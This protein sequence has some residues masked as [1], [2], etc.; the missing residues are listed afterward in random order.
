MQQLSQEVYSNQDGP[1][2]RV[3]EYVLKHAST[4]WLKP[5]HKSS[6]E[7][8]EDYLDF[9]KRHPKI[10]LD[11]GCGV[12]ESTLKLAAAYPDALVVGVDKSWLRLSKAVTQP[13]NTLFLRVDLFDFWRILLDN[14]VQIFK[15]KI[16]YPNP[17]PKSEHLMRRFHAHP[18]FP[19]LI[20]LCADIELRS[21]W[22]I[23]LLEFEIGALTL[24]LESSG[25]HS[26]EIQNESEA[27]TPFE[28]KYFLSQHE[29][30]QLEL[31][32]DVTKNS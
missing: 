12:G 5:L 13:E 11:S 17:W 24:G 25:V 28:R 6:L 4:K 9:I 7:V 31:R 3:H 22:L 1:H 27:M 30:Y 15:H 14:E 10:I 18:V 21:N 16:Y 19:D 8:A 20:R 26:L 2:H 29:L 32:A 23:Y